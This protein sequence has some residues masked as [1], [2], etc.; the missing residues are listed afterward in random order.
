M[1][2]D[3]IP[4]AAIHRTPCPQEMEEFHIRYYSHLK[5]NSALTVD[6]VFSNRLNQFTEYQGLRRCGENAGFGGKCLAQLDV[7]ELWRAFN[8]VCIRVEV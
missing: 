1:L 2:R 6:V 3:L 7:D 5:L 8:E 4:L